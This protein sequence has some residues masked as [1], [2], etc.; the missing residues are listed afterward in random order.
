MMTNS[1]NTARRATSTKRSESSFEAVI[2]VNMEAK[3]DVMPWLTGLYKRSGTNYN[4]E[5]ADQH[6]T[7]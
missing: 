4:K 5:F 7:I 2:R 3:E 6:N 1:E